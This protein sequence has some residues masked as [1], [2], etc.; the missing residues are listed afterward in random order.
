MSLSLAHS[1]VIQPSPTSWPRL[2]TPGSLIWDCSL[3]S[4][5][6]GLDYQVSSFSLRPLRHRPCPMDLVSAGDSFC[7]SHCPS[8]P[9]SRLEVCENSWPILEVRHL[10]FTRAIWITFWMNLLL[11]VPSLVLTLLGQS[12]VCR[13]LLSSPSVPAYFTA[14]LSPSEIS[15]ALLSLL[16]F[17]I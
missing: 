12:T 7:R 11:P 1:C 6:L 14:V 15:D 5:Y 8:E 3:F 16:P 13:I 17:S 4:R 2:V 10:V 9:P